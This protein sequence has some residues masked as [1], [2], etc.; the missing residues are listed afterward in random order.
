MS[1]SGFFSVVPCRLSG[2]ILR[3]K[4]PPPP[5]PPP[6]PSAPPPPPPPPYP[7]LLFVEY[8]HFNW[9]LWHLSTAV[10][11][12]AFCGVRGGG[13]R[14]GKEEKDKE[15]KGEEEIPTIYCSR[16][17]NRWWIVFYLP[18]SFKYLVESNQTPLRWFLLIGDNDIFLFVL[19]CLWK[20]KNVA[21]INRI[22]PIFS[23]TFPEISWLNNR[24]YIITMASI[25]ED[26]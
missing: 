26:Q 25:S 6:P 21:V 8:F 16:F 19:L 22:A 17:E 10:T 11:W 24:Y 5:P 15:E 18:A 2:N 23:L 7:S 1:I 20:K 3:G 9:I 4:W 14:G 12:P 13:G